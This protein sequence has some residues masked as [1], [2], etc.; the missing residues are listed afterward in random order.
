[1]E[2]LDLPNFGKEKLREHLRSKTKTQLSRH[3]LFDEGSKHEEEIPSKGKTRRKKK[4]KKE[5]FVRAFQFSLM[6]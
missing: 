1:M 6:E 4:K 3:W 5:Q 2:D